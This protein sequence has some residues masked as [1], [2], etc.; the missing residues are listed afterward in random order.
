VQDV[1]AP[2]YVATAPGTT[3]THQPLDVKIEWEEEIEP[4][5]KRITTC[6]NGKKAGYVRHA[7]R[8]VGLTGTT[9]ASATC[10]E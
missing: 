2:K 3:W 5:S 4:V 6:T 8:R 7:S 1:P 10:R 9:P